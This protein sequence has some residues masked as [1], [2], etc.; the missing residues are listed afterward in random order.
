MLIQKSAAPFD[1]VKGGWSSEK[2]NGLCG[3]NDLHALPQK[4]AI[5]IVFSGGDNRAPPTPRGG[6]LGGAFRATLRPAPR[7]RRS[8]P[9]GAR[10]ACASAQKKRRQKPSFFCGGT[11]GLKHEPNF[12]Y[13]RKMCVGRIHYKIAVKNTENINA[14]NGIRLQIAITKNLCFC[15]QIFALMLI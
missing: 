3:K 5:R 1:D 9:A 13:K 6:P 15:L 12:N 11:L 14:N 7:L 4:G 2:G 10:F 8:F